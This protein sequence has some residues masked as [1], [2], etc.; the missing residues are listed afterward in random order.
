MPIGPN[1]D[2]TGNL[3]LNNTFYV[4]AEYTEPYY[5]SSNP[6]IPA[7]LS[8]TTLD[9]L[10]SAISPSLRMRADSMNPHF[11]TDFAHDEWMREL[12]WV[13]D[14]YFLL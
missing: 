8:P 13:H 11:R 1:S 12:S 3:V 7:R 9:N 6:T 2:I 5:A 10:Q 14:D 4:P